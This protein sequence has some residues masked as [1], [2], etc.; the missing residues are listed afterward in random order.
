MSEAIDK[1]KDGEDFSKFSNNQ[2]KGAQVSNII[3]MTIC[4][5]M[6]IMTNNIILIITFAL[7]LVH[8]CYR[9]YKLQLYIKNNKDESK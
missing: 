2:L 3:I 5:L 9:S 1:Y 8:Y 6:L 4:V 7:I